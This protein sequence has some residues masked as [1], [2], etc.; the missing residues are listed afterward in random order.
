MKV[1]IDKV[2]LIAT[3]DSLDH[4]NSII[5]HMHGLKNEYISECVPEEHY[6]WKSK[7][8]TKVKVSLGDQSYLY[9]TAGTSGKDKA[10]YLKFEFNADKLSDLAWVNFYNLVTILFY[11]GSQNGY[12]IAYNKFRISKMELAV[13]YK[14]IEFNSINAVDTRIKSCDFQ[15][16]DAGSIYIGSKNSKREFIIY[17]KAKEL[18]DT[19]KQTL[20]YELLRVE[21]RIRNSSIKLAKLH[22]ISN[23]FLRLSLFDINKHIEHANG[24]V[25]DEFKELVINK[26]AY[27]QSAYLS[28]DSYEKKVLDARIAYRRYDWWDPQD[29]W[30]QSKALLAKFHP[31]N[32]FTTKFNK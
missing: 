26:K 27:A 22:K 21:C 32:I 11:D 16:A 29:I 31:D 7:Y 12:E 9:L 2:S 1:L 13:D 6:Y 14:W 17:D 28:F 4:F 3:I 20:D 15:Y 18:K 30:D 19:N 10:L 25:W 8:A 24:K 23:P 5:E